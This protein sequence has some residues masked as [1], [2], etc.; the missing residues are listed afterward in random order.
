M[1]FLACL[2]LSLGMAMAQTQVSGVVTSAEDGQPIIGASIKVI[3]TNTGTVTDVDGAFSLSVQE[4][5]KLQVSYIGLLSKTVK[6]GKNLKIVL[7]SDSKTFDDVVVI[8]YGSARKI[9][10]I[11]G[12]IATVNSDKL[13]NAPSSSA[14]CAN[15]AP[16]TT[17]PIA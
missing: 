14:L 3:G 9:G 13:K 10:T 15:I 5:A 2:F 17:S 4:G 16:R 1:M 6:A 12:N 7:E 11:T 8:G